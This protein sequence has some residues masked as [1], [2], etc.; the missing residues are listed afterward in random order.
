MVIEF[1]GGKIIVTAQEIM[2]RINQGSVTL[3][4]SGDSV[5]LLGAGANVIL[6]NSGEV[7]WSIKLDNEQ[8][9]LAIG[10]YLGCDIR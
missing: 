8:Q 9:L 3:Q 2:C 6:A 10:D 7:K 4:S 5:T 1:S